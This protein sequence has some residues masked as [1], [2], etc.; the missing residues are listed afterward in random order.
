MPANSRPSA[1]QAVLL[2]GSRE[3]P[4]GELAA[5]LAAQ[6][7]PALL[8]APSA[9]GAPPE[10]SSGQVATV[11]FGDAAA[12][13][14]AVAAAG[15]RLGPLAPV[16]VVVVDFDLRPPDLALVLAGRDAWQPHL[17]SVERQLD[18]L[19]A[20]VEAARPRAALLLGSFDALAATPG[21]VLAA[22]AHR[23]AAARA[24]EASRAGACAWSVV[25]WD[26]EGAWEDGAAPALLA[27][28]V[29]DLTA[30]GSAPRLAASPESPAER[31]RR[32]AAVASGR[33]AGAA[34]PLARHARPGLRNPYVAPGSETERRLAEI[35]AA[36][37]GVEPVGMHDSFFDLGGDSLLATQL[38]TRVREAFGCRLALPAFFARPT[39]AG[40]AAQV[41]EAAAERPAGTGSEE[42]AS[43]VEQLA[44]MSSE[45]VA[46]LLAERGLAV[47]D[48]EGLEA[49]P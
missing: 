45:E 48:G 42:I 46:A 13:R 18:A 24:A 23:L 39:P 29:A 19:F 16:A 17:E 36:L 12:L 20:A 32:A 2:L 49:E 4:L 7:T 30:G 9:P 5:L 8:I 10:P 3:G 11:D 33:P 47:P 28:L 15:K 27:S 31:L 38:A 41:D 44:G 40:L 6:G 34:S 1:G 35:W 37:L 26:R 21:R 43:L 14:A 25:D 22:A